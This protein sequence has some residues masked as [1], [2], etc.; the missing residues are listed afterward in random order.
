M[1][2]ISRLLKESIQYALDHRDQ[3]LDYARHVLAQARPTDRV[4]VVVTAR[5]ATV[6]PNAD[7]L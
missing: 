7:L 6:V 3:A 1:R 2:Q 4:Q 5:Q